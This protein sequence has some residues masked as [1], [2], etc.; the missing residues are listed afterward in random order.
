MTVVGHVEQMHLSRCYQGSK[1]LTCL[2]CHN[3][4]D[5]PS[6]RTRAAYYN[7]ICQQCHQTLTCKLEAARRPTNN[8]IECH[9]PAAATEIPHLAFTHH[10]EGIPDAKNTPRADER[11][12]ELT[13]LEP[14]LDLSRLS[15]IERRRS[16][17]LGYLE[18]ANLCRDVGLADQ[19]RHRAKA[20][21]D[22]VRA[23]GLHDGV[24]DAN[25]ARVRFDLELEENMPLAESALADAN[26]GVQDRCTA[27]FLLAD[28]LAHAGRRKEAIVPLRF[29]VGDL[30]RHSM[31]LLLLADCERSAGDPAYIQTLE[32][33]VRI[34]PRL[35]KIHGQLAD[36]FSRTGDKEKADYHKKRTGPITP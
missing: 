3:P 20:L 17:G 5:E 36:H 31:Q 10:R 15:D 6:P 33:A 2:T 27:L 13:T 26:L 30:A 16:L 18:V 7:G 32:S 1:T 9:M 4:H 12:M 35:G 11:P 23:E 25:L 19:Y 29:P 14:F 21:M 8:C 24:V 22:K 28:G 34:N